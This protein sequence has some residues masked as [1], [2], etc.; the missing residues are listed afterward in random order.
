M[1]A[2]DH[3]ADGEREED[4]RMGGLGQRCSR[5]L[6]EGFVEGAGEIARVDG[7]AEAG[8]LATE[9]TGATRFV[10]GIVRAGAAGTIG[11]SVSDMVGVVEESVAAGDEDGIG[12]G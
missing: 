11:R 7:A 12:E 2:A 10:E 3:S 9:R 4:E 5:G 8:A 6:Y 1:K